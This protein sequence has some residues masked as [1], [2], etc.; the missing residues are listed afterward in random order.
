MLAVLQEGSH[1]SG[2]DRVLFPVQRPWELLVKG[3]NSS[4][5]TDT[6]AATIVAAPDL[7]AT[8]KMTSGPKPKI[9]PT[10]RGYTFNTSYVI[11]AADQ[12]GVNREDSKRV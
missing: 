8:I 12:V 6:T 2:S 11:V 1:V 4:S 10:V 7:N 3:P 5:Y 9:E